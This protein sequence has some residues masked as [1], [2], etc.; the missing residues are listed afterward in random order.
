MVGD[1][2]ARG[3]AALDVKLGNI[4]VGQTTGTLYWIDFE[5]ASL[6]AYPAW[7]ARLAEQHAT[8]EQWFD[9]RV[10]RGCESCGAE[11]SV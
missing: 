11:S 6:D 10:G 5:R 3:V 4:L 8:L 1:M 7:D 9:L 2:N